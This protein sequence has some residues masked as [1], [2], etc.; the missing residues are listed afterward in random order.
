MNPF[1]KISIITPNY[2]GGAYLEATIQSLVNQHYP[3]LEYIVIDGGSTDHSMEIINRYRQHMTHIISEPD[4]GLYHA[5][6]K[7]MA[8]ATGDIMGW[9]NADDMHH[10]KSL[11][12]LAEIFTSFPQVQW[13]MGNPTYFDEKGRTIHCYGMARIC[14]YDYLM[15]RGGWLQQESTFWTR[16][17]WEKA[18]SRISQ[19]YKYAGDFELWSRFFDHAQLCITDTLL[20]GFRYRSK[21]QLTLE[22]FDDYVNEVNE[23]IRTKKTDTYYEPVYTIQNTESFESLIGSLKNSQHCVF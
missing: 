20:A 13:L 9:L 12:T 1:P 21:A 15:P 10:P 6:Q 23:I 22:H 7:G 14:K 11:F 3:N 5:I 16:A 17:L 2:N 19:Q 4:N 18:G 8:L